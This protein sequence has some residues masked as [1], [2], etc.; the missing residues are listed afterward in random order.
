MTEGEKL[1]ER[2]LTPILIKR[3]NYPI[4]RKLLENVIQEACERTL[5]VAEKHYNLGIGWKDSCD[6]KS[7]QEH[8]KKQKERTRWWEREVKE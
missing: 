4:V 1:A 8:R 5:K 6:C 3:D 7:C 2:V